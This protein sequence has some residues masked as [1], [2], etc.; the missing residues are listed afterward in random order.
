MKM[1]E[2][3][4]DEKTQSVVVK[5]TEHWIVSVAPMIFN[6][7]VLLTSREEYPWTWTAGWCYD[8]GGAA[9]LAAA[10]WDPETEREPIG[11]KKVAADARGI[12]GVEPS[13]AW[14]DEVSDYLTGNNDPSDRE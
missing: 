4:W 2:K 11:Y 7:R 13:M 5:V 14:V 6:D 9:G 12:R 1:P 10:V 8:K 3:G